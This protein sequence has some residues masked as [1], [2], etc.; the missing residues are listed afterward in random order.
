MARLALVLVAVLAGLLLAVPG[1]QAATFCV[2]SPTGCSGIDLPGTSGSLDEAL[3]NAELNAE[4]DL[5][6]IGPGTYVPGEPVGFQFN[7]PTHGIEIRGDG[8]T[9]TILEVGNTTEPTLKLKGAGDFASSVRDLGVRLSAN[10]GT[11]TGLVL[12]NG[13]AQNV[14]VTAPAGLS[15]GVGVR[16][17][18]GNT[19]FGKGSWTCPG[20]G[21]SRPAGPRWCWGPRSGP[22]S[23]SW[24]RAARWESLTRISRAR[25]SGS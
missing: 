7:D 24:R 21:G 15:D 25:G 18:G 19:Q 8:A 3:S 20:C 22:M 10:G 4:A 5:I 14:A 16:L 6:R 2:G 13:K 12:E 11:P 9:E 17:A 23:R 1:A